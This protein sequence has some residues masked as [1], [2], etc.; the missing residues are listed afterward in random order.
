MLKDSGLSKSF[1]VGAIVTAAYV[2]K[3]I[4]TTAC[5]NTTPCKETLKRQF[6]YRSLRVF[7]SKCYAHVPKAKRS[8]LD[9]SGVRCLM[10]DYLDKFKGYRLLNC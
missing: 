4:S 9:D 8:K 6:D 3:T 1:K 2:R 5:P 7:G 10:L